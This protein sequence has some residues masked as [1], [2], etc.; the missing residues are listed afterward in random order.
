MSNNIY[1]KLAILH[2]VARLRGNGAAFLAAMVKEL[3]QE[4][5]RTRSRSAGAVLVEGTERSSACNLLASVIVAISIANV[6]D[7]G[8]EV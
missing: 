4:L 6:I 5:T 8:L 2:I 3:L 1:C 7:D